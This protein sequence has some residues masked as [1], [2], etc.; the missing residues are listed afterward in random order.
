VDFFRTENF[1]FVDKLL[2]DNCLGLLELGNVIYPR[3]IRLFYANLEVKSDACGL[4][5]ETLVKSVR[6]TLTPATLESIFGLH[7]VNNAPSTLT[8]KTAKDLCL[9][10]FACPHTLAHYKSRTN[11]PPYNVLLP[12]ARLLHYV[13]IRIFY[14]KDYSKEASNAVALEAVYRLMSGYSV[15]YACIILQHMYR[16]AH[17]CRTPSL[18]YGN[19]LTRIFTHFHVPLEHEECLTQPA[20]TISSHTLKSLKFF[21]TATRGW[22]HIS[23]LTPAEASSLKISLPPQPSPNFTHSLTQ[24]QEAHDALRDDLVATQFDLGLLHRKVDEL[25]RLTCLIH[26]GIQI[27]VPLQSTDT[28][29]AE[30]HAA[31]V[32]AST[33]SDPVFR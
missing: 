19:L 24:L 32:L 12:E 26:R 22:Q 28:V 9:S 8:R 30:Q 21:K 3:L 7:Y 17:V 2:R 6:I 10:E 14:P 16:I 1:G 18:P 15:D 27:S 23:A 4:C 33:S 25:I 11:S 13:F 29:F 20:P 31:R 5:F